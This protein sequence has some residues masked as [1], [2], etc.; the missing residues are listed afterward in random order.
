MSG[1]AALRRPLVAV[2]GQAGCL[3]VYGPAAEYHLHRK[4][5]ILPSSL[6]NAKHFAISQSD[7]QCFSHEDGYSAAGH[8]ILEQPA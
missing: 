6:Q 2:A 4:T 5:H 7:T 8:E 1:A 3:W